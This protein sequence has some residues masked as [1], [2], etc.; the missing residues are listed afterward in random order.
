MPSAGARAQAREG[1]D[2][3]KQV[4]RD[5]ILVRID[6]SVQS[7]LVAILSCIPPDGSCRKM[8]AALSRSGRQAG[9][10]QNN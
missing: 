2:L 6:V 4:Q 10:L 3:K 7:T 1:R 9:V 8:S 5:R